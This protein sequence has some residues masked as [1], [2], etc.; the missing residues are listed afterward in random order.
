MEEIKKKATAFIT[1]KKNAN[2]LVD[3]ITCLQVI[4]T[5]LFRFDVSHLSLSVHALFFT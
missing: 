4:I 2:N 5:V 1:N 3:L